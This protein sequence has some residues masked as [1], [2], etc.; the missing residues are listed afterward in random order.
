MTVPLVLI[1]EDDAKLAE[2]FLL[3]LQT[4]GFGSEWVADGEAALARLAEIA[5][6][7]I[8][9]DL[10]LPKVD[11]LTVLK[12]IRA[13][14]RLAKT[15]VILATAD[16]QLAQTIEDQADLVLLKP[17]SPEQLGRLVARLTQ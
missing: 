16:E 12:Q 6:D 1:V 10:H 4:V 14:E 9:L 2:I 15:R 11:G 3:T 5:P 7:L 8:L 17:V 13:D